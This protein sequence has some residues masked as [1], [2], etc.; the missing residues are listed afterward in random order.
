MTENKPFFINSTLFFK[1]IKKSLASAGYAE[2][3]QV[4]VTVT[5]DCCAL[6]MLLNDVEFLPMPTSLDEMLSLDAV[7]TL[8]IGNI[9]FLREAFSPVDFYSFKTLSGE[10]VKVD[11][12]VIK[13]TI[14]D[15]PFFSI[16]LNKLNESVKNDGYIDNQIIVVKADPATIAAFQSLDEFIPSDIPYPINE[17]EPNYFSY[18]VG[19]IGQYLLIRDL[20]AVDHFMSYLKMD[21]SKRTILIDW[22]FNISNPKDPK[23]I[24]Q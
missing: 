17:D 20:T 3:D 16:L 11:V 9:I 13:R 14:D 15:Q 21:G 19:E 12:D 24:Y 22:N 2:T 18:Q 23:F 6:L 1:T 10:V 4:K 7:P 5:T 8:K